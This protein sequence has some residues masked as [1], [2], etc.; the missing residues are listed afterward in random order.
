MMS[1]TLEGL[2]A[3][4]QE[5]VTAI[6]GNIR[7]TAG[8]G[9][10][11]TRVLA[12]RYAYLV[13]EVGISPSNILCMTFTNKAAQEMKNRIKTMVR[14]GNVNDFVCTIHGFC[15]KFLRE[16]IFR[17]GFPKNF[18][19]LDEEDA[20][21]LAKQVM[22]ELGLNK[23]VETIKQFLTD[24]HA[25]KKDGGYVG[26]YM[27]PNAAFD[28]KDVFERY[29]QLQVKLFALDF[30]DLI[31][32]TLYVLN[33]YDEVREKWQERINYIMLDEAQDCNGNDWAIVNAIKGDHH[34]LFIVGDPDQCIYEWRGANP[35]YF[36]DFT[37]DKDIILNQNYRS[38]PNILDVANS[39]ISHNEMRIKKDLFTKNV[40]DKIVLHYH[41]KSEQEE[42]D[43]IA[44]QI[45]NIVKAGAKYSDF[46]ILYRAQWISRFVEEALLRKQIPYTIWGGVR[47][48]ERKE[49][50]DA[51][52]YLRLL[53]YKD[54]LSFRRIINVPSR[55]FGKGS[56]DKLTK[57]ADEDNTNLFTALRN[58]VYSFNN[59][60]AIKDFLSLYQQANIYK[61]SH[62]ISD[63][64]NYLLGESGYKDAIRLDDDEER[65]ENL[66]EL[67]SSIKYYEEL[68]KDEENLDIVTYLQDIALYTNAD[69]K[70]DT[71]TV[72][73][74]TIHQA[75]GLEFPYVF[76]CCL[77]EGIFPSH[78]S[79]RDRRKNGLE[80]ERRLM[81]VAVT[82]AEKALFLTESEGYN[83]STKMSKYPSRFLTEIKDNLVQVEEN[84]DPSLLEGTK[85]AIIQFQDDYKP[86]PVSRTYVGYRVF[87][88]FFGVGV[89]LSYDNG[90]QS[91]KVR[92][93]DT[94]RNI[95]EDHLNVV[96]QN[97]SNPTIPI[98]KT[99]QGATEWS[100]LA[101]DGTGDIYRI[102][103]AHSKE[104]ALQKAKSYVPMPDDSI[105]YISDHFV[106][107]DDDDE[108]EYESNDDEYD[109]EMEIS[110]YD[111]KKASNE[112]G[113]S[114]DAKESEEAPNDNDSLDLLLNEI[115]GIMTFK[116][117]EVKG[118]V[119]DFLSKLR[120]KGF[121]FPGTFD[122]DDRYQP[123]LNEGEIE[124]S[125]KIA[126]YECSG[127]VHYA[128]KSHNVYSVKV[129]IDGITIP[130]KDKAKEF[131]KPYISKYGEPS[132]VSESSDDEYLNW[133][134][135]CD[136]TLEGDD[137]I[138]IVCNDNY[139]PT[140]EYTNRS[141]LQL[142]EKE[143]Q[144][145][146]LDEI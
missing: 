86:Q 57:M 136:F 76:V 29:L 111:A 33:N 51:L 132:N 125:G 59:N 77:T 48:F 3:K 2:N 69:Y 137:V 134:Y 65:I 146:F 99:T 114:F 143:Q 83:Y 38:T 130:S 79:I 37:P 14:Q 116:G 140:I 50:K 144:E 44:T 27:L 113:V 39:I 12:H 126:G 19:I 118:T 110:N 121:W 47:F 82:R 30:D 128:L 41:G 62:S 23:S 22:G 115:N 139:H 17:L 61:D 73:L 142:A 135:D 145:Q 60:H 112:S 71:P 7:V 91:Y 55:K 6:D 105:I 131:V 46:A 52:A 9:S 96:W 63:T 8:A 31:H 88:N 117:I 32:F 123:R 53:V 81:Y 20:K 25:K 42:G 97:G 104:E 78:R 100:V 67:F 11:K 133:W 106:P 13:N 80:E 68:N 15:V 70:K 75:K 87:N 16:E 85:N 120:D 1:E 138:S 103:I 93:G 54:D 26:K 119:E 43:W 21:D 94:I 34:N 24:I 124:V 5:A 141:N 4:Q 101:S 108:D 49:I 129:R 28:N 18:A 109:L 98:Q 64:L 72:K 56:L 35:K 66:E 92:F 89:T 122:D 95:S 102:D 107:D 36:I 40:S 84:L 58:H 74:M 10:G 90:T 127:N 45:D